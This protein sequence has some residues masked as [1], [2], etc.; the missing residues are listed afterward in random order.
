MKYKFI[1]IGCGPFDVSGDRYGVNN[2]GIYV[3]PIKEFLDVLPGSE[4]IIKVEAAISDTNGTAE[5]I[6]YSMDVPIKYYT[7]KHLYR[8]FENKNTREVA[9]LIGGQ[10]GAS[11]LGIRP[12]LKNPISRTVKTMT[13]SKLFKKYDV[14]E[15]EY[16]HIDTEGHEI[17]IMSQLLD[18]MKKNEVAITKKIVFEWNNLCPQQELLKIAKEIQM[19]FGYT[20]KHEDDGILNNDII[21]EKIK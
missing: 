15:I 11:F 8:M 12:E 14:T 1:D 6:T 10:G 2:P 20:I 13:L 21:M 3:E 16:L 19:S 4:H 9:K 7:K 18:I 17:T 5:I